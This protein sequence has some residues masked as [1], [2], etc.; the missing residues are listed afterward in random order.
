ML[1]NV[2]CSTKYNRLAP[3]SHCKPNDNVLFLSTMQLRYTKEGGFFL[4][5]T[6]GRGDFFLPLHWVVGFFLAFTLRSGI[7]SCL[8][9]EEWDFFLPFALRFFTNW[10]TIARNNR[11][12]FIVWNPSKLLDVTLPSS[13]PFLSVSYQSSSPI[14]REILLWLIRLSMRRSKIRL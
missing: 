5:F 10:C 8:Y 7:F 6:P 12:T 1:L 11:F 2:A 9:T 3:C 14:Y 4:A 13:I